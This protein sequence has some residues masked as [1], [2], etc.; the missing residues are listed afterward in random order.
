MKST[1]YWQ[2]AG[3]LEW[4]KTFFA[5]INLLFT[6]NGS[7][8]ICTRDMRSGVLR[9][10][11]VKRLTRYEGVLGSHWILCVF[12]GVSS[13]KTLQSPS[14]VSVKPHERHE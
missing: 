12:E 6:K 1:N 5:D 10:S 2:K 8:D 9:C 7:L 14:L 3:A 4:V 11:M 13:G